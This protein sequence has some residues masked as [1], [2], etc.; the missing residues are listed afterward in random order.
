M[1]AH[2]AL[3]V[4]LEHRI[5]PALKLDVG[6][7]LGPECGVLFGPSG[8]G[9][10]TIL[11]LIAG[12]TAPDR[13]HVRV[14]NDVLFDASAGINVPLRHRRIGMIFQDDLL[15]PHLNVASNIRFG[16]KGQPKRQADDRVNAVATLCGVEP[17]LGRTPTTLSG[18]ERQ[19]VGLARALAPRPRLLLCDEPVSALDLASRHTLLE[20]LRIVQ[21]A[22]DIP[23]LYVT[24]SPAEAIALGSRLFLLSAGTIIE[25][26][27]PL[28][29]LARHTG[30]ATH[31]EG[32]RNLFAAVI[33]GHAPDGGETHLRVE[34]GPSL[35][36]PY[37]P[38]EVG[39]RVFVEVRADEILLARGPLA[40]LSARNL[41]DGLV[42]RIVP[43]GPEAEIVVRTEGVC[44]I[45][46]VVAPAVAA[47]DL[48]PSAAVCL[49]VKARSCRVLDGP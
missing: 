18:G 36:V 33:E 32:V 39:S 20:R 41:I 2:R 45:A 28:E 17:L 4:R 38:R 47:L 22:E 21:R 48:R 8:T 13:G 26:G 16:L 25:E 31:L 35:V 23:L 10:T 43:H 14:E 24:H 27:S 9:K 15:F 37:E 49:I 7:S 30:A 6:L 42:E 40:G 34:N 44:W 12:L 5:H 19:R 46:S 11:R 3:D 1:S 29:V